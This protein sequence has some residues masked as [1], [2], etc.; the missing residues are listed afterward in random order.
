MF[1]KKILKFKYHTG[2]T[3]NYIYIKKFYCY[4][5]DSEH[6][7]IMIICKYCHLYSVSPHIKSVKYRRSCK[8]KTT[9]F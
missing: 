7:I 8:K 9:K 2:G 4:K 3:L 5:I 6:Q 1:S